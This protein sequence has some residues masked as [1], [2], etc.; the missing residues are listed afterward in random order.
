MCEK[1]AK[2]IFCSKNID[3]FENT[4][5]TTVNEIVINELIKLTMLWTTA[6]PWKTK[7]EPS[8]RKHV[9]M[10]HLPSNIWNSLIENHYY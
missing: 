10:N 5:A 8:V 1:K 6:G 7:Y 4:L 9:H 3:V 2:V